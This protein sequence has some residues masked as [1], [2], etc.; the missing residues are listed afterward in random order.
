MTGEIKERIASRS[1]KVVENRCDAINARVRAHVNN[2]NVRKD[3]H[4]EIYKK[5]HQQLTELSVRLQS[6]GYDV[7]K[8]TADL[9]TLKTMI[10]QLEIEYKEF[11]TSTE[12]TLSLDCLQSLTDYKQYLSGSRVKLAEFRQQA[13]SIHEFLQGTI[14]TDLKAIRQQK[15]INDQTN[16]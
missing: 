11:I 2:L 12:A 10:D 6:K 15:V 3:N 7:T 13:R 14:K 16:Q 4:I 9:L 8:L 1:A 5:R